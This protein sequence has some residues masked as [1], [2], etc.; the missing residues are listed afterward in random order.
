M[1]GVVMKKT[2]FWVLA[3]LFLQ[4][5]SVYAAEKKI[6]LTTYYP[7]PYGEYQQI[8]L[9]PNDN[10]PGVCSSSNEG[11]MFYSRSSHEIRVCQQA[12]DAYAWSPLGG[13]AP[14]GMVAAFAMTSVPSGWLIC[15]GSLKLKVD[16]PALATALGCTYG[17]SS[18]GLSF[19]VPDYR[20]YFLRG[21]GGVDPNAGTR[22]I[23]AVQQDAFKSHRHTVGYAND[24]TGD[25]GFISV[26]RYNDVQMLGSSR[27]RTAATDYEW[28][29][30]SR[31]VPGGSE[32]RPVES[33][34]NTETRPKNMA[35]TYCIKT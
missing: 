34:Q 25:Y 22:T 4:G 9:N 13:G 29:D 35:I 19:K 32:A 8:K 12:G 21:L 27:Y 5:P 33:V 24:D 2:F 14:T 16:Y 6:T 23:G 30:V 11:A 20:G 7:S 18:D 3:F 1:K 17:C 26:P 10:A 31:A 28:D 15:D